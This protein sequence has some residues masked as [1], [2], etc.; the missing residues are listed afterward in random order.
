MC[1]RVDSP[2]LFILC[3]SQHICVVITGRNLKIH[4]KCG[5]Q[6]KVYFNTLHKTV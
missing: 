4:V 6:S 3:G 2:S 1:S 5:Q